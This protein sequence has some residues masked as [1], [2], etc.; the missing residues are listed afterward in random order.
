MLAKSPEALEPNLLSL[1]EENSRHRLEREDLNF[2]S[3]GLAKGKGTVRVGNYSDMPTKY[4]I[5]NLVRMSAAFAE[6][7]GLI[8]KGAWDV[9]QRS[10]SVQSLMKSFDNGRGYQ[11]NVDNYLKML[12]ILQK[13]RN[14]LPVVVMGETG[15]GK[16]YLVQ[17][18]TQVLLDGVADLRLKTMHFGVS[19]QDFCGF[20]DEGIRSARENQSQSV[21]LFFDE[22]NTSPLQ[23]HLNMLMHDRKFL[24]GS[25]KGRAADRRRVPSREPGAGGRVQPLPSA[26]G[27]QRPESPGY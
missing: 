5:D 18:L 8:G 11:L 1:V 24:L 7:C 9:E 2:Q 3:V 15:C 16:T 21:W 22:F 10:E 12:L 13:A 4:Y 14:Q 20:V 25:R 26:V 27:Q 23:A 19:V 17:F 6:E